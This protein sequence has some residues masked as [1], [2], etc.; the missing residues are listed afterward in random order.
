MTGAEPRDQVFEQTVATIWREERVS[1]P[2]DDL[3]RAFLEGGLE[4]NAADYLRFHLEEVKC[5]WCTVKVQELQA[6]MGL[7]T[8][9]E[10]DLDAA[11][12]RTL[13]STIIQLRAKGD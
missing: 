3:L 6:S 5:P 9:P 13:R 8:P 2:H 11:T 4:E 1:C 10:L 7:P 12:E